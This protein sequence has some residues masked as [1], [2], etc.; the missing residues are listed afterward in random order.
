MMSEPKL[1]LY[2]HWPFCRA[3]CPYCDFN[4]HVASD[5]DHQ[6]FAAAFR[7]ELAFLAAQHGRGRKLTSLFFGGGTPSLM[8]PWLVAAI[9]DEADRLLGFENGAEISAE[10]NP[11]SSEASVFRDFHSAGVNRLSLGVQALR[12]PEL[13]FLG[14]EH[15]VDEALTAI[16]MA[17]ETFAHVSMDLI[18]ALKDQSPEDWQRDLSTALSLGLDHMSLYQL[19]IEQ[20]TGF[21]TRARR[22]EVLTAQDDIAADMYLATEE[23]MTAAGLPAYEVSNYARPGAECRHN[24]VYWHAHDWIGTGPGAHSRLTT[25]DGRLGLAMRRSPTAWLD[26]VAEQG[27]GL[28]MI[29]EDDRREAVAEFLMMGLRLVTGISLQDFSHRFGSLA[30]SVNQTTLHQLLDQGLLTMTADH[31]AVTLD[32]RMVLNSI[33]AAL[34]DTQD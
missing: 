18:Y 1:A 4:S 30:Q 33:L 20:G 22:G 13:A 17:R 5:I 21:Y 15:S 16:S 9:I 32:G 24:L 25:D 31:L 29:H 28:D 19:T 27:H 26:A 11:T 6:R 12:A 23:I 14:R 7:R 8:P 3:K 34:L 2:V 10:A